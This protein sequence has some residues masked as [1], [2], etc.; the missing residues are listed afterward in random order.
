MG[1]DYML[2]C[3]ALQN[4]LESGRKEK[5]CHVLQLRIS[6]G[7]QPTVHFISSRKKP[8]AHM[9]FSLKSE[10]VDSL[11]PVVLLFLCGLYCSIRLFTL[12]AF[13]LAIFDL[14]DFFKYEI[15]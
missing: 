7:G 12:D 9:S 4:R 14:A 1:V 8:R 11:V 3:V 2:R 15:E 10:L 5:S 6:A 13:I